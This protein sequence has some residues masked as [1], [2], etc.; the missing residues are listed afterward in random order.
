M[1]GEGETKALA[2]IGIETRVRFIEKEHPACGGPDARDRGAACLANGEVANASG[3]D[4][5]KAEA[6]DRI[7]HS[8]FAIRGC[9][10]RDPLLCVKVGC[11][12]K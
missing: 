7:T 5:S 10:P 3:H 9:D 12:G 1:I 4:R 6:F 2:R 8:R 11:D